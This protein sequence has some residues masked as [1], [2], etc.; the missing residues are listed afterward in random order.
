MVP[1]HLIQ[2]IGADQ[3]LEKNLWHVN[4][5]HPDGKGSRA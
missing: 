4:G 3:R 5:P 2:S 1:A